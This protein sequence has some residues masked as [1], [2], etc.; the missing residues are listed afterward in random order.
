MKIVS[1]KARFEANDYELA[2]EM[3][4]NGYP[5]FID[6]IGAF[7]G[8]RGK[9]I[10]FDTKNANNYFEDIE[11]ESEDPTLADQIVCIDKMI[12]QSDLNWGEWSSL[13]EDM[14]TPDFEYENWVERE[15][16]KKPKENESFNKS[17][18]KMNLSEAKQILRRNG[19]RIVEDTDDWDEADMPAG[20]SAKDRAAMVDKHEDE[21]R[22]LYY[23]KDEYGVW[24]LRVLATTDN[25]DAFL[26]YLTPTF[27]IVKDVRDAYMNYNQADDIYRKY[28]V[29]D[30]V[31]GKLK[32]EFRK[33]FPE[34][35]TFWLEPGTI[36]K[37]KFYYHNIGKL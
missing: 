26:G 8:G 34:Y 14:W 19:Y 29:W 23:K 11:D 16:M 12:G 33:K 30:E 31:K 2:K 6:D 10:G 25:E 7:G 13:Y 4:D 1:G 21:Y 9:V 27:E 24:V 32:K 3:L 28:T 22:D 37:G 35:K 5:I 36:K 20:M 15:N 18:S 17:V